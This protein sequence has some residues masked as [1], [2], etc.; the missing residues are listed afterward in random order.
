MRQTGQPRK[1]PGSGVGGGCTQVSRKQ[2]RTNPNPPKHSPTVTPAKLQSLAAGQSRR[3]MFP[4]ISPTVIV[5]PAALLTEPNSELGATDVEVLHS[6]DVLD[7][8]LNR[9]DKH[10]KFSTAEH[11]RNEMSASRFAPRPPL[12]PAPAEIAEL[13]RDEEA[14]GPSTGLALGN[15]SAD[16]TWSVDSQREHDHLARSPAWASRVSCMLGIAQ[17]GRFGLIGK[18]VARQY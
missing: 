13:P 17:M 8:D 18:M 1:A 10:D 11:R 2:T 12:H 9:P 14:S 16:C 15:S 5:V 3:Y 4:H 6:L 7:L